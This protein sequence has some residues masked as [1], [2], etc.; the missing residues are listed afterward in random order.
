LEKEGSTGS[1]DSNDSA[2]LK[3]SGDS[4]AIAVGLAL[5]EGDIETEASVEGDAVHGPGAITRHSAKRKQT[6]KTTFIASPPHWNKG[7]FFL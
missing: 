6:G 5:S 3:G 7:I 4:V 2:S 1:K